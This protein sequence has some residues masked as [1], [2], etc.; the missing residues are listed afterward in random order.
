MH[1]RRNGN[2]LQCSCLENPWGG[3]AW[4][5]AVYG[6][7]QSRTRLKRLS[8]R[9]LKGEK[10]ERR[11]RT[12]FEFEGKMLP[13]AWR[14]SSSCRREQGHQCRSRA[15]QADR[16]AP[17]LQVRATRGSPTS[18]GYPDSVV[19]GRDPGICAKA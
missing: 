2:T 11:H 5:A 10:S 12:V 3:G 7:S 14:T 9:S 16:M 18:L 6:V 15:S 19:L 8:S 1:W 4:W 17:S 13:Y